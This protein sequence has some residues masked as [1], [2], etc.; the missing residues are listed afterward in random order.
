MRHRVAG[1]KLNR[2]SG[3][4]RALFRN[5][6]SAVIYH[7]RIETTEAKARAVRRHVE[8][9]ITLA[10]RGL[11]AEKEDPAR[12]VHARRLAAARLNRWVTEPDG[13]RVDLVR[14]LFDEIAPRYMDRPGGYTRIIKLGPRKG[15]AAPM[16]ILELVEE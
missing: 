12:G 5:L 13:T 2:S 1:K 14:K 16:A 4:R 6:V 9:L 8:K 10:K 11:A 7:E 15:D 3:H